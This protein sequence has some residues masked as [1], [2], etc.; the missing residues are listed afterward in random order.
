M[1]FTLLAVFISFVIG[2]SQPTPVATPSHDDGHEHKQG[3]GHDLTH[4]KPITKADVKMPASFVELVSRVEQYRD[5]IKAAIDAGKPETGHRALDELD[6]VLGETMSL[7]QKSVPED[8]LA[9]VNE[10]RQS[11]RNAFLEIHQSIDAKEKP[12]YAAQEQT[13]Q[14]AISALKQIAGANTG[15]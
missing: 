7:A 14:T 2:C 13:I 15:K 12:D 4:D 6:I 8:Q 3:E 11:I 9:T 5:Q 10:S 1:R